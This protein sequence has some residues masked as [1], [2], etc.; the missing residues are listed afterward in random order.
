MEDFRQQIEM[1][2][3]GKDE[4]FKHHP[5]SPIPSMERAGFEGLNYYH[6]NA[7]LRFKL[8]L[9]EHEERRTIKIQ[10][11]KGGVQEFIRWG[12]FRFEINGKEYNLHAYNSSQEEE[13]FWV[14][15]KDKTNGKE[16][17]G[18]GR[19]IDLEHSRHKTSDGKWIL[20]FNQAYNPFCAYSKNYVC[21]FIPPENWLETE[22]KAGEKYSPL[23]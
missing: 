2:R 19:Y 12:E 17:Y 4:F 16:T 10:D 6:V 14:P 20:D 9:H 21:P 5:Q 11:S 13:T 23:E 7:E 22:I 3:R 18:A 8:E 1:E 15:F